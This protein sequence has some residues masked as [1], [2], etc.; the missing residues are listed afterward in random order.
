M[1]SVYSILIVTIDRATG[2]SYR[3]LFSNMQQ[4]CRQLSNY[5]TRSISLVIMNARKQLHS[6]R[7]VPQ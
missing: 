6:Y 1:R 3:F 2:V 4:E 5:K 7:Y